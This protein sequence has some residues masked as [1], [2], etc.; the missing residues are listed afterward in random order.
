MAMEI[1]EIWKKA[2]PLIANNVSSISFDLYIKTLTPEAFENG[3]FILSA[4]STRDAGYAN[5][6]RHFP[7]IIDAIKRIAPVV[8][9]VIIIDAVEKEKRDNKNKPAPPAE[10]IAPAAPKNISYINPL[11]TFDNFIIGKSNE[12]VAHAAEFVAKNPCKKINPL[13]IWG[14]SGMGKTHLINAIANYIT[15][16]QPE[17]KVVLT[18]C[19]KFTAEYVDVIK[20]KG[21]FGV[22]REKH[23][24]TDVL[25][26]DDI[27]D[28]ANRQGTQ[29][30]FF[31]TF[32]DLFEH[33]RQIVVT[34]DRPPDE[35]ATLAERLRSRLKSGITQDISNP[36]T[37]M[38]I[39]IL[40]KKAS[41]DGKYLP[42]EVAGYIAEYSFDND[43]NIREMEGHLFKVLFY[44][45]L[46]GKP[47]PDLDDCHN[48]LAELH[49]TKSGDDK[50]SRIIETVAKYF[51]ITPEELTGKRRTRE[52][53]EPRMVCA[54]VMTENLDIPLINIGEMLG[55][56][57][58]ATVIYS[59]NK[60]SA[61]MKNDRRLKTAIIDIT[62]QIKK[63]Q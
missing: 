18:S 58:H 56:R 42:P 24:N 4:L 23:R 22:F 7:Y 8:E 29:D 48:A 61:E 26:V 53:A 19:Q 36:D 46:K 30:E 28:L 57:D 62:E 37:E 2:K 49:D 63:G 5:N 11:Q 25:L 59:R 39:A 35:I 44:A 17:L 38:R 3:D 12:F 32:N 52:F 47:M 15:D 21:D 43:E 14:R 41:L 27:Q 33:R 34:S 55:G 60:I 50:G 51:N 13:F 54:Y 40:H 45:E 9:K 20:T 31:N 6:D 1:N 10:P 16:N